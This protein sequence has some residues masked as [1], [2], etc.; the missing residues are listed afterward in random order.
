VKKN[1]DGGGGPLRAASLSTS[2]KGK[3]ATKK[4]KSPLGGGKVT[5]AKAKDG[6]KRE[7]CRK[8]S[9]EESAYGGEVEKNAGT[10]GQQNFWRGGGPGGK[11]DQD[12][13]GHKGGGRSARRQLRKNEKSKRQ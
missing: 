2:G 4:D 11:K 3:K 10:S 7:N 12:P 13:P 8:R 9:P 5:G 6:E 1:E